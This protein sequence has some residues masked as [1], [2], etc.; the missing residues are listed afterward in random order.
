MERRTVEVILQGRRFVLRT[1]A[2][3]DDLNVVVAFAE[4]RLEETNQAAGGMGPHA[5]SLLTLL[6]VCEELLRERRKID[7]LREK[8]R[9][10]SSRILEMLEGVPRADE[11]NS[12]PVGGMSI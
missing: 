10:K 2:G 12:P 4:S 8:I 5:V 1:G 9:N 3:D 7:G 6:G 11:G